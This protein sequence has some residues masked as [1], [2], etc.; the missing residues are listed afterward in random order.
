MHEDVRAYINLCFPRNFWRV[1][2][3]LDFRSDCMRT[4]VFSLICL[5]VLFAGFAHADDWNKTYEVSGT[6]ELRAPSI[7]L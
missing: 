1:H 3:V 6:P 4:R 2:S 7:D 5:L